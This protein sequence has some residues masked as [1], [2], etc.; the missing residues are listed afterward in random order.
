MERV[1]LRLDND[2]LLRSL[3]GNG[4]AED[5]ADGFVENV[6]QA[7]LG[8]RGALEV[9]DGSNFLCH[10]QSLGVGDGRH[11]LFPELFDGLTVFA[12]IELGADEDDRGVWCVMA[13]LGVP[14]HTLGEKSHGEKKTHCHDQRK[15]R[16]IPL[17]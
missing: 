9:F 12:K 6:L 3:L 13:D 17:S 11:S 7:L 8:E 5:S 1:F 15:L 16:F 4:G 14:L 2:A 10:L